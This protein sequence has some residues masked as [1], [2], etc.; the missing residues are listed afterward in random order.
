MEDLTFNVEVI[1]PEPI[2]STPIAEEDLEGLIPEFVA[3]RADLN[4]VEYENILRHL[5]RA[6]RRAR[7]G[8]PQEVLTV[9]FMYDLHRGMFSD[10]WRWAGTQRRRVTNIGA[11]PSVIGAR[12]AEALADTRFWV[13][14]S[15]FEPDELATRVHARLVDIHPFPNGNGRCT[16]LVADLYLTSIGR[17][18]FS[19]GSDTLDRDGATRKR[20]LAALIQAIKTDDFTSLIDFARS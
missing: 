16:R 11:D 1:G 20:Y 13:A 19:W 2:G 5:P 4:Q 9:A 3:T 17:P 15:V 8:G 6:Q 7:R 10:V 18:A 12:C 14:E